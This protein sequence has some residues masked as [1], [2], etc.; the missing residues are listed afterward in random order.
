MQNKDAAPETTPT[1][2]ASRERIGLLVSGWN[3][4]EAVSTIVAAEAAGVRQVWMTQSTPAPDTLIIFGAAAVQTSS[5]RMG[6]AIVPIYPRNPLAL[7][8]QAL[9]LGYLAPNRV[10]LGIGP[11]HKPTME[12]VYGIPMTVPLEHL[13]EYVA[14]L[15]AALWEGKV[16]YHGRFYTIQTTL[17]H[18]PRTPILISALREGAFQL[19]GE[20]ADGAISWVCPVQYLLEK[21]QPALRAGAR[22]GGRPVPPLVAHIPVALSHDRPAVL[23]AARQRLA[24]YGRLPFYANM[25]A[26]AGFPVAPDGTMS[27]ALIDNLVVSGD[28]SV[29][30]SRL[31]E[32]LV[33]GLDEL[34]V[35]PIGVAD[36]AGELVRLMK[37]VG[38][39]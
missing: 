22:K 15:R 18:V 30:A 1:N 34:L 2:H 33:M 24:L 12:N 21:A 37:L 5:V 14:V 38:Q 32:L 26:D 9:A 31:A 35:M 3:A 28:E 39:L 36:P 10:R 8:Q 27:D 20:L 23:T 4:A 6:S 13:R 16:D 25:F 17:Q 29:V 11:S 7:A 19:A